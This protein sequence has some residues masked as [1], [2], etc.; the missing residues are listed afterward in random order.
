METLNSSSRCTHSVHWLLVS[1]PPL[2]LV[3]FH[4]VQQRQQCQSAM[5]VS[6][7]AWPGSASP[8]L[9]DQDW[10]LAGKDGRSNVEVE[11]GQA[12]MR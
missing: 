9:A 12:L 1:C 3:P 5:W 6:A 10:S 4:P 2:T 7:G 11:G 8:R